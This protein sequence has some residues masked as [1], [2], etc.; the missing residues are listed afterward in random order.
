[1]WPLAFC[2][3]SQHYR[4]DWLETCLCLLVHLTSTTN[5][6]TFIIYYNTNRY[7]ILSMTAREL[8][9]SS[10]YSIIPFWN[11]VHF[12]FIGTIF[13][14]ILSRFLRGIS[15]EQDRGWPRS[16]RMS[17]VSDALMSLLI[18]WCMQKTLTFQWWSN[19]TFSCFYMT[20]LS[21]LTNLLDKPNSGLPRINN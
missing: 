16:T 2:L 18:V 12:Q 14:Y 3:Y 19:R 17:F 20:Q 5:Y 4:I 10:K 7:Q 9:M 15:K 11:F 8:I 13:F 1:M 6:D 21:L